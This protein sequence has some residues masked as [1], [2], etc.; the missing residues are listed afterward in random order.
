MKNSV[1][2]WIFG[3]AFIFMFNLCLHAYGHDSM[4]VSFIVGAL[5]GMILGLSED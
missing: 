1:V 2:K 3:I 4:L 5:I